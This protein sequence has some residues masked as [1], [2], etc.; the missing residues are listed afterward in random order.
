MKKITLSAQ[1]LIKRYGGVVALAN[2]NLSISSGEVLALVGANGSGK[3]TLGKIITGVVQPDGGDLH[4]DGQPVRLGSP[5]VARRLGITAVYQ[6]LSLIADMSVTENIWLSHEPRRWGLVDTR[7]MDRHT[8]TLLELFAGTVSPNLQPS[9]LIGELPPDEKQVVEILK[10]LSWDPRLIILDEATAS[11]DSRQVARL[12]ELVAR[13]QADGRAVIIVSHRMEE[14]YRVAQR[15][16]VLRG[17][18]AV[19]DRVLADTP[20][21]ELV[22]LMIPDSAVRVKKT[23]ADDELTQRPVRLAVN[24]LK[25]KRLKDISLSIRDG[26]L[27]GIGGLRGQ[28]QEELLRAL[29]G[30]VPYEGEVRVSQKDVHFKHPQEA[31]G[32]GVALVPGDRGTEGLLLSRSILE[33][34]QL[35]S[36][37]QYGRIL[38]M[39]SARSDAQ[40]AGRD[41]RLKMGALS[42]PVSSLSGGN[43]QKV[44]LGKWLL[45]SPKLLLLN[46]PTKGVD[47]GAKGEFYQ[48]LDSLRAAGTA[49]LFYSSDD[50]ELLWLCDRILVMHDGGVSAELHGEH[51]THANLVAASMGSVGSMENHV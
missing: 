37:A 38:N 16:T 5:Q 36:W 23:A 26:E 13:W 27:L 21:A 48:I 50:E 39:K 47:V 15:A 8:E 17:G 33:N 34:L 6:E 19:A 22:Q 29:F 51:L 40:A 35:P 1:N 14:N 7:Q 2:G 43:A 41:L 28:G 31:I 44:V 42:D 45:R 10:A 20:T 11:L 32:H 25:T 49:V 18:E 24:H 9:T 12:F 3:S 46:D 30:V 4:V